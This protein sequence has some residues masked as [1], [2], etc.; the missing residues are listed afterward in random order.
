MADAVLLIDDDVDLL[1]AAGAQLERAGYDVTRELS[2]EAGLA[3]WDR[4]RP[5]VVIL[6]LDLPGMQG[7]EVL[8]HLRD[9]GAAVI[10]VAPSDQVSSVVRAL[11]SGAESWVAK[12]VELSLLEAAVARL[13]DKVRTRRV[14]EAVLAPEPGL[15]LESLGSSAVMLEIAQQ[16]KLLASSERTTVLVEGEVGT[17]KLWVSRLIHALSPRARQPFLSVSCAGIPAGPVTQT[18]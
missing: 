9:R 18:A 1:R 3:T 10:V 12:P 5:D 17:G 8:S 14:N 13:A 4:I 2:G 6:D 7:S 16:V 15:T 11:Q